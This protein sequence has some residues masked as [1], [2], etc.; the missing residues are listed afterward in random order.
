MAGFCSEDD[1]GMISVIVPL[2]NK[3]KT[4]MRAIESVL[5]QE[6]TPCEVLVI[7][8]GSSDESAEIVREIR[9]PLIR[10]INQENL[11]PGAARNLGASLCQGRYLAFLDADDEWRSSHLKNAAL[12]LG[13]SQECSVYVTGYDSGRFRNVQPNLIKYL[14]LAGSIGP[15]LEVCGTTLKTMVDAMHSSCVVVKGETFRALGGFFEKDRCVYGEDSFLWLRVLLTQN[16]YWDP[17]ET[18]LFHVEDSALGYAVTNRAK[19]R[20]AS[21]Y[22]EL[23]SEGMSGAQNRAAKRAIGYFAL[24][25]LYQ[26]VDSGSQDAVYELERVH[27]SLRRRRLKIPLWR[28][29]QKL[30]GL[31]GSKIRSSG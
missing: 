15:P 21:L 20:P 12:A 9:S 16:I 5:H 27:P 19:A 8:D 24:L 6:H 3:A 22:P 1:I 13:G 18:V 29:K 2:F 17:T 31:L 10:L 7:N 25:D 23:V 26:L 4:I 28:L 30:L 11:G 14:S